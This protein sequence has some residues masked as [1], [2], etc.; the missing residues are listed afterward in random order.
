MPTYIRV[1]DDTTHHEYDVDARSLRPGM[2]PID[3]YPA[4]SG[5]GAKPRPAKHRVTKDGKPARPRTRT[6]PV[7]ADTAAAAAPTTERQPA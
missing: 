2:T 3:G 4:N 5:P 7:P 6:K 1:R